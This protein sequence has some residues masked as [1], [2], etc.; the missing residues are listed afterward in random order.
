MAIII[1]RYPWQPVEEAKAMG[2]I[3]QRSNDFV[4]NKISPYPPF[5]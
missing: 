4:C 2:K 3:D 1:F 5:E